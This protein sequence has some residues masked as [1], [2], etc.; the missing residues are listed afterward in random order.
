MAT[1]EQASV[2]TRVVRRLLALPAPVLRKLAGPPIVK[3]GRALNLQV[4]TIIAVGEKVGLVDEE[5][6]VASRR[7][8]L[9]DASAI[10]MPK[11]T[12]IHV[13][14]RRIPG[15]AGEIPIRV[16]RKFGSAGRPRTIMYT[17]GGGWVTGGLDSHDGSCRLIADVTGCVVVAVDYRLAPEHPF[18]AAV[19]DS[20]AAYRWIH[21]HA[22]D[23]GV[24]PGKVGVMGDSAGGN[25]A[26]VVAQVTR[27]AEVP[28]PVAQCLI[29]PV[30]E[31]H[32][33]S[34]S[35]GLFAE[36][37]MLTRASME[38]F[39]SHYLP[40]PA[41]W[42]SPLAA[43]GLAEDLSGLAPAAVFTAGFD[44]LRDEGRDY[45]DALTTAG[46]AV[47]YRCYDDMVHGFFGMGILPG[48]V[49]IATEICSAMGALMTGD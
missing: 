44:P 34:T 32:F 17:H 37:F 33:T 10:G 45:A 28:A 20:I 21:D 6:D 31:S 9:E 26:A 24:E 39:R 38:W 13:V 18:P 16:Y 43:P 5:Y 14:D 35:H 12:G 27:D 11:R 1:R 8:Q 47:Q 2:P 3:D 48:G 19:D 23:L 46:V 25:L 49:D 22:D 40:D 4:Q 29:Y 7:K 36:G 41:D 15:P 42:E 30:T